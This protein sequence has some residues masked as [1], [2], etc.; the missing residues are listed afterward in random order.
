MTIMRTDHHPLGVPKNLIWLARSKP[1]AG[2]M[3]HTLVTAGLSLWWTKIPPVSYTI[4]YSKMFVFG[5]VGL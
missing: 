5:V 3:V 1:E 2:H 4:Y